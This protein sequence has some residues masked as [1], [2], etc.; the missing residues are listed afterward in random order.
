MEKLTSND[1]I[2]LFEE[3]QKL[4]LKQITSQAKQ[5]VKKEVDD[6]YKHKY[7]EEREKKLKLEQI[8]NQIEEQFIALINTIKSNLGNGTTKCS[9]CI[10]NNADTAT[11]PCGHK[12][13]YYEC[14]DEYHKTYTHRGCP[15]CRK[16]ILC[17]TRIFS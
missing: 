6:K 17:V 10:E 16:D 5:K 2:K 7:M 8:E 12:F 15:L 14:I 9:I 11:I 4:Q 1:L 13:F 3:E